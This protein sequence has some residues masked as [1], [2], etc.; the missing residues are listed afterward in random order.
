MQRFLWV[1]PTLASGARAGRVEPPAPG[2]TRL[3]FESPTE[4]LPSL[5]DSNLTDRR[6]TALSSLRDSNHTDRRP[7]PA[8]ENPSR[9][10]SARPGL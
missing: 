1:E 10:P 9:R 7:T 6:P 5:R 2:P 3:I 8:R 4:A